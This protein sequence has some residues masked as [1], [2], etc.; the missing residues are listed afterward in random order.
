MTFDTR[1]RPEDM[2]VACQRCGGT[3]R[4]AQPRC[5]TCG[6]ARG[7][8]GRPEGADAPSAPASDE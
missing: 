5:L 3:I 1:T 6:T 8:A 2:A 4:G 7:A